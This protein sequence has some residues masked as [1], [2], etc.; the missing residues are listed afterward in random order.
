MFVTLDAE[1][2]MEHIKASPFLLAQQRL[3][4]APACGESPTHRS[5]ATGTTPVPPTPAGTASL[6]PAAPLD[7]LTTL[8]T[9]LSL[10]SAAAPGGCCTAMFG[11]RAQRTYR[12]SPAGP[13]ALP[14]RRPTQ[15]CPPG[16]MRALPCT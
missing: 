13:T 10:H 3:A 2:V 5:A 7:S 1:A 14:L 9:G 16:P 15:S 11:G 6:S 12:S 8:M 4:G